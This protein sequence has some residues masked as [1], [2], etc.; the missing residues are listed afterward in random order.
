[1]NSRPERRRS[2]FTLVEML[3]VVAIVMLLIALLLPVIMKVRESALAYYCINNLHVIGKAYYAYA[4]D[5]DDGIPPIIQGSAKDPPHYVPTTWE[6]L[7][8]P[9]G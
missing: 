5:Y 4:G 7:L 9:Y 6:G 2:G 8:K 3:V 1:M